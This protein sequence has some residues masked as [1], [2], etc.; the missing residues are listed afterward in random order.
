MSLSRSTMSRSVPPPDDGNVV[1]GV[2]EALETFLSGFQELIHH[3]IDQICFFKVH[4]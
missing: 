1:L 2:A 3:C 4:L